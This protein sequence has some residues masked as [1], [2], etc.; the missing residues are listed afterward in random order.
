MP[1]TAAGEAPGRSVDLAPID[2]LGGE[3]DHPETPIRNQSM[4]GIC[5]VVDALAGCPL[6]AA[7][8]KQSV[9]RCRSD[10][11]DDACRQSSTGDDDK[12]CAP[13]RGTLGQARPNVVATTDREDVVISGQSQMATCGQNQLSAHTCSNHASSDARGSAARR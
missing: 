1:R 7:M 8:G 6:G 10:R 5:Y 11:I 2:E 12:Q 3:V 4:V 9:R 13:D